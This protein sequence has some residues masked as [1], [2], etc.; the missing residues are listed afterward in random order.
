M[1]FYKKIK[2]FVVFLIIFAWVFSGS[3]QIW[4][5]PSIPPKIQEAKAAPTVIFLTNTSLTEWTVPNDW[6]SG[7]NTIE[8]IGAG[9]GGANGAAEAGVGGGGGASG[10]YAKETNISL[11]PSSSITIQIGTG[12]GVASAGGDTYFNGA[13][14]SLSD[15]CGKGGGGASG[16]T[17]GTAQS[18][19]VGTTVYAGANGG[20][21]GAASGIIT[22]P[23][24]KIQV[25]SLS[26]TGSIISF[27]V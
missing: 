22:F 23:S 13:S 2:G 9:G 6:N 24:D 21:G 8:V 7:D 11:T 15:V 18:G 16:S 4:N 17:Q 26:K 20:N 27:W 3:F 14:C 5:N 25:N 12:G 19:S 10:A 1:D